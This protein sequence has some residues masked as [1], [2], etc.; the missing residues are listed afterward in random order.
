MS[1]ASR[2]DAWQAAD[3]Y[4][5]FMG[6]W[7]RLIAPRFLTWLGARNGLDWLDVGCGTG[8]LS[9]AILAGYDPKSLI[10]ID[11]SEGFIAAARASLPDPRVQFRTG[12]ASA[13]GLDD[14]GRDVVVSGLM[15]NFIPSRQAALGEMKRVTRA[16]GTIGFYV[17]DYPGGGMGFLRLF[18]DAA[19]ALDPAAL[20]LAEAR[21]F[22]F[23]TQDALAELA[24]AAGLTRVESTAIE[25]PTVFQDFD[26]YWRPFT[27]GTGPAP[28]YCASLDPDLRARLRDRLSA[29]LPRGEDGSIT[30]TA[31]AWAV[32]ATAA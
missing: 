14:T 15:L 24:N 5:Y 30:L 3:R 2:H 29:A 27:L 20:D 23:C 18:W 28:G 17:W 8:A 7:S 1:D 4:E 16:G 25:V 32:K 9:A 12:D 10:A 19:T 6:R 22:P 26:D 11:Q 31:R 13:L 21:R